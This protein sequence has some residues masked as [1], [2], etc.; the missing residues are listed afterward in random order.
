MIHDAGEG[1]LMGDNAHQTS[2]HALRVKRLGI[3]TYQE[4]VIY[5]RSDCR[6]C[7][8]EGFEAQS[9]VQVAHNRHAIIATLNIGTSDLL[10]PG[11]PLFTEHAEAPGELGY[12][13]DY[14]AAQPGIVCVE[15]V[16]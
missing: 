9:R 3:G 2:S 15:A 13:F 16:S 11:L 12:A 8:A 7:R 4:P 10:V 5:M 1:V 6:V 14:V